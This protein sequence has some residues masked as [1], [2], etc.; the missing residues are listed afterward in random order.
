[1]LPARQSRRYDHSHM[2][3][4]TPT[5]TLFGELVEHAGRRMLEPGETL[6]RAGDRVTA[7]FVV[8]AGRIRLVRTSRG[9]S[10][11]T[12]HRA[13]AGESFAEPALFSE[14][15]HCDAVAE[16]ASQVLEYGKH[17]MLERL[18]S[19]PERMMHLLRHLALQ[20]QAL[21]S[22]AE[23]L[24]LHSATDRVMAYFRLRAGARG[25]VVELDTTWKQVA[26]EVGLTHEALYRALRRL[27]D[28]GTIERD[29]PKV[30]LRS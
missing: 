3:D 10:E 8:A 30:I 4:P 20:V 19:D 15:Y 13:T 17:E 23:M 14:R 26:S 25:T 7:V 21:R 18:A 1:M 22:R 24:A 16:T 29:G 5:A 27:E 12:L 9:G 28:A 6:F 11:V 2:D